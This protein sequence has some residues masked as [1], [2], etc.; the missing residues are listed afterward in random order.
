MKTINKFI[1]EKLKINSKSIAN[2]SFIKLNLNNVIDAIDDEC[3]HDNDW[4]LDPFSRKTGSFH[5]AVNV[6][7]S[8]YDVLTYNEQIEHIANV[9]NVDEADLDEFIINN[10]EELTKYFKV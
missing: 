3:C 6:T 10:D 1:C 7:N 4:S 8:V 2:T 9:L 5:D